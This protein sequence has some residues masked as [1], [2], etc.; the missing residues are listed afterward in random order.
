MLF[1]KPIS[2]MK[3]ISV[4]CFVSLT[5]YVF[6]AAVGDNAW[7]KRMVPESA[8]GDEDDPGYW[9]GDESRLAQKAQKS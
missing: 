1:K 9:G 2:N 3:L 6:A 5:S 8:P 4:I 7:A